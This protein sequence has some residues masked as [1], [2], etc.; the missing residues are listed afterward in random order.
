[1]SQYNWA[2]KMQNKDERR[3]TINQ[4]DIQTIFGWFNHFENI[5]SYKDASYNETLEILE[6][7]P[8]VKQRCEIWIK[9]RNLKHMQLWFK[10][11]PNPTAYDNEV[12]AL[13]E[14]TLNP[15]EPP[16]PQV[17]TEVQQEIKKEEED[18][19]GSETP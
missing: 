14:E 18:K 6:K 11:Y 10:H 5:M 2:F 12:A 16:K 17:K 4:E 15:K 7:G 8:I 19:K 13:V 9:T 3:F 1:M